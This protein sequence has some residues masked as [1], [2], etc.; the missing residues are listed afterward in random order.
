MPYGLYNFL[1]F[2]PSELLVQKLKNKKKLKKN[3][4]E[5]EMFGFDFEN[6]LT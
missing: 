1:N 2:V 6:V 5:T 4:K 3:K